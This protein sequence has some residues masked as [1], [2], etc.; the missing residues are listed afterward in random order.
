MLLLYDG[1][2]NDDYLIVAIA[3]ITVFVNSVVNLL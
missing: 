2:D 1:N 3:V